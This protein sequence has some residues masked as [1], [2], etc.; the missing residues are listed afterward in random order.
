MDP[1]LPPG[2]ERCILVAAPH[3]SN[4]DFVYMVGAFK[5][6]ELDFRFTIKREWLKFPFKKLLL[7]LGAIGIDRRAKTP[8][9][10]RKSSVD[11]MAQLFS[12]HDQLVVVVTPEGTRARAERWRTG[13][14][15]TALKAGV[16]IGLGYLDYK[17]KVAG[18]GQV[19]VPS[20]DPEKDLPRIMAFY[21]KIPGCRPELFSIDLRYPPKSPEKESA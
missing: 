5:I 2:V 13:F 10:P 9:E 19:F 3:T 15:Y 21:E 17:N 1:H 16:P 12:E 6:L 4:W 18:I 20:G 14:Y 8:G 7:K 11:A